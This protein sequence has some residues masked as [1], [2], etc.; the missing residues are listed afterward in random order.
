MKSKV[1]AYLLWFFLGVF[2]VHRFY[3]EKTGTGILWL[4]T[5]GLFGIGWLID[6]FTLGVQ[7]NDYNLSLERAY[8]KP[9][10]SKQ[11]ALKCKTCQKTFASGYTA[12]P[13]C[14]SNNIEENHSNETTEQN[15]PPV[16]LAKS[17]T[18]KK[19]KRC[20]E[21]VNEDIFKCPKCKGKSFL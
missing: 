7:V 14:S 5:G 13:Y 18:F 10:L 12:C 16:I 1:V 15:I 4:L 8:P 17:E 6:L 11:N 9:D 19:C 20:G 3:L 2:G 21:K